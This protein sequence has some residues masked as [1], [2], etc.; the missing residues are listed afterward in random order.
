[1]T[2]E[3]EGRIPFTGDFDAV[4]TLI[5]G[6]LTVQ[7]FTVVRAE[8]D[9]IEFSGPGMVNSRQ[10][11]ICGAGRIR[12]TRRHGEMTLEADFEG[13]ERMRRFLQL[14]LTSMALGFLALF[15]P[16]MGIIFGRQFGVGFGV[17]FAQGWNWMLF[18][19]PLV[20]LPLLPWIVLTPL[21]CRRFRNRARQALD[22]LLKSLTVAQGV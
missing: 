17:P 13:V 11:A 4:H 16:V 19:G 10:P 14:F 2:M 5:S 22:D 18:I 1:M 9:V 3:Y 20:L 15:G 6:T 7:G 21:L 12:L 8:R